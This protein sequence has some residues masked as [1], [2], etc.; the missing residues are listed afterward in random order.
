MYPVFQFS[1]Y[2]C[3]K[4]TNNAYAGSQEVS[5]VFVKLELVEVED[6][7]DVL[8]K[9]RLERNNRRASLE[10]GSVG[11]WSSE[12]R[13]LPVDSSEHAASRHLRMRRESPR[14]AGLPSTGP[15]AYCLY[16][17]LTVT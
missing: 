8:Y 2:D 10:V 17:E 4:V 1:L 16:V 9:A 15:V 11:R 3:K 14:L 6:K 7:A 5:W 13:A 12:L